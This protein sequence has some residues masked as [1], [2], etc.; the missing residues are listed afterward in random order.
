MLTW[1]LSQ[2]DMEQISSLLFR[3]LRKILFFNEQ[4]LI[5][6]FLW[7]VLASKCWNV[8]NVILQKLQ[9]E[10]QG[11]EFVAVTTSKNCCL[12]LFR[13]PWSNLVMVVLFEVW[14]IFLVISEQTMTKMLLAKRRQTDEVKVISRRE[15]R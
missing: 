4:S 7:G 13:F 8:Y 12:L 10:F 9:Q 11:V 1:L 3:S 14:P 15:N 2:W 5:F 6:S